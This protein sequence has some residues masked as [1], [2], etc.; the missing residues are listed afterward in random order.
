MTVTVTENRLLAEV[1]TNKTKIKTKRMDH[2][3]FLLHWYDYDDTKT[4]NMDWCVVSIETLYIV[5]QIR[6]QR[7]KASCYFV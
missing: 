2:R 4:K 5:S 3:Y 6:L 7:K 1:K